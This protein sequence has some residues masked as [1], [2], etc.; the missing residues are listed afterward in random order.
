MGNKI[1]NIVKYASWGLL[2]VG[3][4]LV[5]IGAIVGFE[6]NDA[7]AI[8]LMLYWAYALIGIA[9]CAIVVLGLF[10]AAKNN[11]AQLKTI[12]IV[13]G[14]GVV[15]VLIAWLLAPA[16]APLAYNGPAVSHS[17]LVLTDTMLNLTYFSF[18]AAILAV[19]FSSVWNSIRSKK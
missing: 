10:L 19:I 2:L 8:D 5:V 6:A 17:D 7:L 11:P 13:V 3:V 12:G 1:F 18:C 16:S 4:L 9:L 15:L 14:G